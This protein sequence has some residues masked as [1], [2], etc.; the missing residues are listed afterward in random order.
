MYLRIL[1]KCPDKKEF[2]WGIILPLKTLF[3]S[4]TLSY[5]RLIIERNPFE[6]IT[7][8]PFSHVPPFRRAKRA[9]KNFQGF[10]YLFTENN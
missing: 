2:L 5:H 10:Y 6:R 4:C 1:K 7:F 3:L 9:E 8:I